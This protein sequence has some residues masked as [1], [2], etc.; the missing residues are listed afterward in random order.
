MAHPFLALF[1][2]YAVY[3]FLDCSQKSLKCCSQSL[4]NLS[5]ELDEQ[6]YVI[7]YS[8]N[9]LKIDLKFDDDETLKDI[10]VEGGTVTKVE[11]NGDN[12]VVH[13]TWKM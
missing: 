3:K 10:Q 1:G 13:I 2:F 4:T 7:P 9:D 6:Q 8:A 11:K 5:N 12:T